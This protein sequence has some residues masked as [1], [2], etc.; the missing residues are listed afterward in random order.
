MPQPFYHRM[1]VLFTA[2]AD[3]SERMNAAE[4]RAELV[5]FLHHQLGAHLLRD[6]VT[7]DGTP[8]AMPGDPHG[9]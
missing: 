6:S 5:R 3:L 8:D 4:F 7:F 9:P 2:T 1:E